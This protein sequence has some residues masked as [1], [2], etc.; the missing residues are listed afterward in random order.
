MSLRKLYRTLEIPGAHPL[1]EAHAK[2]D[3]AVRGAYRMK[4]NELA[5]EFLF[6]LNQELAE[7]EDA[8]Q[9][10]IGPGVPPCVK[11]P[12]EFI[13]TDRLPL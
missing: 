7:R 4:K 13:T 8:M 5:I 6:A 9:A 1:K 2:L 3:Q 12:S 11:N 10:V